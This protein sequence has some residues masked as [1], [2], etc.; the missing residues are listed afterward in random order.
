[1]V[2]VEEWTEGG[3]AECHYGGERQGFG[4]VGGD[5]LR[6]TREGGAAGEV[7]VVVRRRVGTKKSKTRAA[8]ALFY[9]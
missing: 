9:G 8:D 3:A 6:R 5:E 1:M 7:V 4:R 2:R